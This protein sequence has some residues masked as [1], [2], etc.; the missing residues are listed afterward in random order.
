V[1]N[2][3]IIC[4]KKAK[5]GETFHYSTVAGIGWVVFPMIFFIIQNY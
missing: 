1:D 3:E 4:K 5:A 2:V